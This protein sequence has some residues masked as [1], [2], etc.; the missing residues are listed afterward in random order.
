MGSS[1]SVRRDRRPANDCLPTSLRT[2]GP[3]PAHRPNTLRKPHPSMR[4]RVADPDPQTTGKQRSVTSIPL[5]HHRTSDNRPSTST[6][7]P[8][9]GRFLRP[10]SAVDLRST[11]RNIRPSTSAGEFSTHR[12]RATLRN[13]NNTFTP[14]TARGIPGIPPRFIDSEF[15]GEEDGP[16]ADV[17]ACLGC[18]TRFSLGY[19]QMKRFGRAFHC[20][21]CKSDAGV[22]AAER[23]FGS[24]RPLESGGCAEDV[25]DPRADSDPQASREYHDSS[26]RFQEHRRK[27]LAYARGE[28]SSGPSRRGNACPSHDGV[29]S[30]RRKYAPWIDE[31]T[32]WE[33]IR[34]PSRRYS[35]GFDERLS[36]GLSIA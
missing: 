33:R 36:A 23:C 27:Q 5:A 18:A 4:T 3:P 1:I 24:G 2:T 14:V 34:V 28:H 6:A 17:V 26:K 30:D 16:A 20:S 29:G 25:H 35:A 13:F 9:S 19:V 31:E 8:S 32:N 7:P 12:V 11:V 10:R 15:P 21:L 22:A